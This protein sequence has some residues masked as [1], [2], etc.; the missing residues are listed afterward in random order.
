MVRN[1]ADKFWELY[2]PYEPDLLNCN[3]QLEYDPGSENIIKNHGTVIYSRLSIGTRHFYH[4]N[5]YGSIEDIGEA[6]DR[7]MSETGRCNQSI[8]HCKMAR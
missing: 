3:W 1:G 8:F 2:D 5:Y 6:V 4:Q 7:L